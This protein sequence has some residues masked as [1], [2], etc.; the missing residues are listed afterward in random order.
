MQQLF[1]RLKTT[2]KPTR[3]HTQNWR[4]GRGRGGREKRPEQNKHNKILGQ[5]GG[6]KNIFKNKGLPEKGN[7]KHKDT[8]PARKGSGFHNSANDTSSLKRSSTPLPRA[9]PRNTHKKQYTTA[10]ISATG[11]PIGPWQPI[12]SVVSNPFAK[13]ASS[14]TQSAW[15]GQCLTSFRR[16]SSVSRCHGHGTRVDSRVHGPGEVKIKKFV[17]AWRVKIASWSVK[18]V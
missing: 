3:P 17:W 11:I 16:W 9:H 5:K 7:P 10:A 14:A 12:K 6:D 18:Y 15:P 8:Q 4:G 2:I 13:S 1:K